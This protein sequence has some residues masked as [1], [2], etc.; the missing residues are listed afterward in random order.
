MHIKQPILA[1]TFII[2]QKKN[3]MRNFSD[4]SCGWKTSMEWVE[5]HVIKY[6]EAKVVLNL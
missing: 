2:S 3:E 5:W 1:N 6:N 4:A